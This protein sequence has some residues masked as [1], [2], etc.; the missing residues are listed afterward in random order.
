MLR[1]L[2]KYQYLTRLPNKFVNNTRMVPF[3][4]PVTQYNREYHSTINLLKDKSFKQPGNGPR[5]S[6]FEKP[7][8]EV[9]K[10]V[11]NEDELEKLKLARKERELKKKEIRSKQIEMQKKHDATKKVKKPPAEKE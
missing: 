8:D 4:L 2:L 3:S 6:K 7:D 1:M 11:R 9:V 5:K 10:K